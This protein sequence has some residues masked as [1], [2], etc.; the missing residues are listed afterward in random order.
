MITVTCPWCE[1]DE[2]LDLE[3]IRS[4]ETT[5]ECPDCGTSVRFVDEPEN[6]LDVAA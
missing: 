3:L 5:F 1:L 4:P 6:W 2:P